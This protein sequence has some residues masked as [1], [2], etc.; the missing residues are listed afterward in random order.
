[1][2]VQHCGITMPHSH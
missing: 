1:M 2:E